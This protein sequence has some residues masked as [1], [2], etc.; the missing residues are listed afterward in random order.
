MLFNL[1]ALRA[2]LPIDA[3]DEWFSPALALH[4]A[5]VTHTQLKALKALNALNSL[6]ANDSSKSHTKAKQ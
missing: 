2:V 3:A 5:N 6:Q 1:N 4:A